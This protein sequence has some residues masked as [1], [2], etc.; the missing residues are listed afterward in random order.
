MHGNKKQK[1]EN[2]PEIEIKKYK[3][4][5]QIWAHEAPPIRSTD[6][7]S[8]SLKDVGQICHGPDSTILKIISHAVS[9]TGI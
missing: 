1:E 2:H 3:I 8:E 5:D 6:Y 7:Q 4:S 9:V